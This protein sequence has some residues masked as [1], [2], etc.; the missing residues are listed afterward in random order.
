MS[1]SC[2]KWKF[3]YRDD[4]ERK[5]Q[6]KSIAYGIRFSKSLEASDFEDKGLYWFLSAKISPL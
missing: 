3:G 5:Y 6:E 2:A 1:G 4:Y